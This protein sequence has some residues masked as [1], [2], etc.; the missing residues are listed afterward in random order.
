MRRWL[1]PVSILLIA[2]GIVGLC[3]PWLFAWYRYGFTLLLIGTVL[4]TIA[5]HL[6]EKKTN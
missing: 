3:Q 2:L 5:V 6:P 1:E 4:F